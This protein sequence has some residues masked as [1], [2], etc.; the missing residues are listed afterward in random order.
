MAG[1]LA[2]FWY[3]PR[4][5]GTIA[6]PIFGLPLNFYLFALPAWQLIAGWLLTLA[7]IAC[8]LAVLFLLIA[9]SSRALAG[10]F[11]SRSRCPGAG[12]LLPSHSSARHAC[13][14]RISEPL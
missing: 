12:S 5:L 6:D 8:L 10:R 4:T 3:A 13:R 2:L 14:A 1:T 7:V 11:S 9:G